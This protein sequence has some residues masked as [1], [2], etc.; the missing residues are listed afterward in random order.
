MLRSARLASVRDNCRIRLRSDGRESAVAAAVAVAAECRVVH[1]RE[2]AR[3][4]GNGKIGMR[5]RLEQDGAMG[6][7]SAALRGRIKE[8]IVAKQ[9]T[10][11]SLST[12]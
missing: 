2:G 9:L 4:A 6:K 12:R 11:G 8:R 10:S 3:L 5:R 7:M 1:N